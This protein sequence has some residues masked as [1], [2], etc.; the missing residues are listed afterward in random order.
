[1][2]LIYFIFSLKYF[3]EL[4]IIVVQIALKPIPVDQPHASGASQLLRVFC[5]IGIRNYHGLVTL[6]EG[7]SRNSL[8]H[9]RIACGSRCFQRLPPTHHIA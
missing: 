4:L 9:R 8:L 7:F 1:M 5:V 6:V 2:K 3:Y